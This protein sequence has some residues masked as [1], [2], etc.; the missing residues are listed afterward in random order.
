V[1]IIKKADKLAFG[2][3]VNQGLPFYGAGITYKVPFN[4]EEDCDIEILEQKYFGALIKAKLDG[5]DIGNIVFNP[6]TLKIENV[7]KGEHV[8]ELELVLTRVN[9]F[10][11]HHTCTDISWK[12]PR[13]WYNKGADWSYEYNLYDNGILKSPEIKIYKK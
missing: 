11:A 4:V 7:A 1:S 13:H 10:V 9:S 2:S 6:Y 3:V 12:G 8:L 5:N